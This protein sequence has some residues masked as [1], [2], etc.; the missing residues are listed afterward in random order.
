APA[1]AIPGVVKV[2][3]LDNAVA[4]IAKDTYTAFKGVRALKPAWTTADVR[5][6]SKDY[7]PQLVAANKAAI[8]A[9]PAPGAATELRAGYDAAPKKVEQSYT[10]TRVHH[11]TMEP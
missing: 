6:S 7:V 3:K 10:L 4:V 2:V 1:M 11:V 9:A 8:A 5:G